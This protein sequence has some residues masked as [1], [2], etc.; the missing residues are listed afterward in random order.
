MG[1]SPTTGTTSSQAAY[2]LRRLFNF[3][4]K[5][6]RARSAAPPFQIEPA[7][8][9]FDLILLQ[10]LFWCALRARLSASLNLLREKKYPLA[11]TPCKSY[12][13]AW[14]THFSMFHLLLLTQKGLLLQSLFALL[15]Y[16][17][18]SLVPLSPTPKCSSFMPSTSS[19]T[20]FRP[21]TVQSV[22]RPSMM[23]H[24]VLVSLSVF[25]AFSVR[26]E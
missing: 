8:L 22:G 25:F 20:S 10:S 23:W 1:S 14:K 17:C 21:Q 6:S 13:V 19:Q 15:K 7:S 11:R 24:R 4:Q 2:R 12:A 26:M 3:I 16:Q 5:S 18:F 9:G